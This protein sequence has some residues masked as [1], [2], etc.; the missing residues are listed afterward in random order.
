[1]QSWAKILFLVAGLALVVGSY[2]GDRDTGAQNAT[3]WR[4]K[5][6]SSKENDLP[7]A[8]RALD[9]QAIELIAAKKYNR[10]IAKLTESLKRYPANSGALA[11]RADCYRSIGEVDKAAADYRRAKSVEPKIAPLVDRML[12]E[13]YLGR[14]RSRIDHGDLKGAADDLAIAAQAPS[15]K[16]QALSELSYI[17]LVTRDFDTCIE[18]AARSQAADPGFSDP[19][20]NKGLCLLRAGRAREAIDSLSSAIRIDPNIG[21]A[22]INRAAAYVR[23]GDCPAAKKDIVAAAEVDPA[24]GSIANRVVS[25]CQRSG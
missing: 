17:A 21:A 11:S 25:S 8:V 15:T 14:G 16:A 1:M 23:V 12:G 22:Y 19:R 24:S 2:A 5:G 13:M 4:I 10:A 6:A 3:F 9:R 18:M 7:K 20:I